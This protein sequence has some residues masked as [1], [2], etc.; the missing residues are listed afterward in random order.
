VTRGSHGYTSMKRSTRSGLWSAWRRVRRTRVRF[1][2][3]EGQ[4]LYEFALVLPLLAMLLVGI[5]KF[6]ILFYD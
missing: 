1:G 6:G 3:E 5:I 4:S 2:R